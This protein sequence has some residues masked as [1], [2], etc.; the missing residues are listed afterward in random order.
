M[1]LFIAFGWLVGVVAPLLLGVAVM[2]AMMKAAGGRGAGGGPFFGPPGL[3]TDALYQQILQ[4]IQASQG[5]AQ[6]R[7]GVPPQ[8]LNQ[9]SQAQSQLRQLDDLGRQRLD[10]QRSQLMSMAA[11]AGLD[12][13]L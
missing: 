1:E 9:W 3:P 13:K 12:I 4:A 2:R 5:G 6:A 7:G 10:L 8:L 11:E